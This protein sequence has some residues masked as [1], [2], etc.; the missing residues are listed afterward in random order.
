MASAAKN[1]SIDFKNLFDDIL[2]YGQESKNKNNAN[3][4]KKLNIFFSILEKELNDLEFRN[5]SNIK[6]ENGTTKLLNLKL[7]SLTN[8]LFM[9]I[10]IFNI[11]KNILKNSKK[12]EILL[13]IKNLFKKKIID[14]SRFI[15]TIS[16]TIMKNSNY[17]IRQKMI[18][19]LF[20]LQN[21]L[22]ELYK[23]YDVHL[24][25]LNNSTKKLIRN[26]SNN[27]TRKQKIANSFQIKNSLLA[28]L[29]HNS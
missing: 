25:N 24:K 22:N 13:R 4:D 17:S 8:L 28:N 14:F 16:G 12:D 10:D 2:K 23:S 26:Y 27:I 29:T 20:K 1:N 6:F 3:L 11:L 9:F 5:N 18:N 7:D 15:N 21:E 19:N